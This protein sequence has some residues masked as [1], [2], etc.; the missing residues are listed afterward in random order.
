MM[1]HHET[2]IKLATG[3]PRQVRRRLTQLGFRA[4]RARH[5]ENNT[6]FDFPG[7]R[8]RRARCLLRLRFAGGEN[9]L[10]YKGAPVQSRDYKIRP[11]IETT[12][13]NGQELREILRHLGMREVFSYQKHRT[14]YAPVGRQEGNE[15]AHAFFDETPIGNFLEL[16]GPKRWIDEIA[17]KLGYLRK[18]YITESYAALYRKKCL[19][20]GK[21]PGNMVFPAKES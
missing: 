19:Q 20:Q 1:H 18:D 11:E 6:L 14:A 5:F 17:R 2:E 16:E 4:V 8:L 9:L 10:T 13:Q 21:K 7:Q 3:N 15:A 12:V